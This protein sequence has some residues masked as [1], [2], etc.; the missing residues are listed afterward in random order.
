MKAI[1]SILFFTLTASAFACGT[2]ES[3]YKFYNEAEDDKTRF[4][5]LRYLICDPILEKYRDTEAERN[6]V[7][8]LVEDA[9]KRS[10]ELSTDTLQLDSKWKSEYYR[11]LALRLAIRFNMHKWNVKYKDEIIWAFDPL[12]GVSHGKIYKSLKNLEA[13]PWL[14]TDDGLSLGEQAYS[15]KLNYEILELIVFKP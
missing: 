10:A 13:L 3:R 2:L 14:S 9:Q 11:N 6:M 5:H 4:V 12:F 7:V 1:F 15:S 8:E